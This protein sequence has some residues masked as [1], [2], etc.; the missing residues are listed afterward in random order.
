[1][2]RMLKQSVALKLA[3]SRW[4]RAGRWSR[5]RWPWLAGVSAVL[6]GA[7]VWALWPA[8]PQRY[9]PDPRSRQFSSFTVCVLTGSHGISDA[10]TAPV[11]A[12][13]VDAAK[14]TRAQGSYL[15]VPAPDTEAS[16]AT[17]V[18]TL[19][20]RNCS[21]IVAVGDSE[22]AAVNARAA[23]YPQQHFVEVGTAGTAASAVTVAPGAADGG[24]SAVAAAIERA[25]AGE[26]A[27]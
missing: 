21:L 8:A 19:A 6:V 22:V 27:G 14:A 5:R 23:A 20:S 7:V 1:V 24:R 2:P 18:D 10:K 15:S 16:A 17:Y 9:V 3:P 25:V 26:R 13:V 4:V 12:G 11:W